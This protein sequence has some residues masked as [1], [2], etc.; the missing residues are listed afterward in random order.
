MTVSGSSWA[1]LLRWR[2]VAVMPLPSSTDVVLLIDRRVLTSQASMY[3]SGKKEVK[4]VM[5]VHW[6]AVLC[7]PTSILALAM[8]RWLVLGMSLPRGAHTSQH[9]G[10]P[11]AI[12]MR[13]NQR[14]LRSEQVSLV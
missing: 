14:P 13:Q 11:S 6:S 8:M 1:I 7:R 2:L 10:A 12:V 4:A 5:H 9:S 3:R